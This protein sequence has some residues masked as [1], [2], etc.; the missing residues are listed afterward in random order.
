MLKLKIRERPFPELSYA[1]ASQPALT[2]WFI[3]SIEGLSGRDRYAALYDFWRRQVAPT[4]ERVFS[5]MLEL[6]DVEVRSTDRWP[7][8]GLPDTPLVIVANHPFGIGDGIAVLSLVEQLGRPFRVMIHKDLL[9]IREMEPYS[10][11]IDFSETKD[12]VKNNL[13]VRHE[14]VRLLREGVT[15]VV[16]PAG[17]VATAPKGFGRARDL[18]WKMFP[19]R[20]VQ[21]AK[22][23]VV[24]MHF[25]G[26]NGRL[27][28]LVSGPMNMAERE[29]RVAKF[30]GKA[31]LTLRLSMLIREFARLSGKTIDVRVG[32]LLSWA[33]LESLRDRKALL[34]RLHRGVF[35]LAPD[36]PRGRVHFLQRRLRKAA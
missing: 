26:Q 17:G 28:H 11:P 10:L 36:A 24:P 27:F 35:D 22:A 15:I 4:G 3:H 21:D 13:A 34:E 32:N 18:P 23:S 5:R 12:A 25:S 7:P 8:A 20:L 19:A 33:E 1:N 29:G 16:F 2:R 6:I 9:K 30:V 14:A 31:S